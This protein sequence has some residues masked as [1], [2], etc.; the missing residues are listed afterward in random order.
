MTINTWGAD[1]PMNVAHGGTGRASL[2]LNSALLGNTTSPWA[3]PGTFTAGTTLIGTA[4]A[5]APSVIAIVGIVNRTLVTTGSGSINFGIALNAQTGGTGALQVPNGTTAQEPSPVAGM[6]RYD[7]DTDK[8]RVVDNGV[9]TD[10]VTTVPDDSAWVLVSTATP[11]AATSVVFDNSV[12]NTYENFIVF[13]YVTIDSNTASRQLA[14]QVSSDNGSTWLATS[15]VIRNY[16]QA[17]TAAATANIPVGARLS[18]AI[19]SLNNNTLPS[20][21]LC[22]LFQLTVAQSTGVRVE[23]QTVWNPGSTTISSNGFTGGGSINTS[24]AYDAIRFL[25]PDGDTITGTVLLYGL[26]NS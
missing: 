18:G 26:K 16:T 9:W 6:F 17:T 5:T 2:T 13:W 20:S 1:D 8:L 3:L 4:T 12:V 24:T 19:G 25:Q 7:D 10:L 11:S 23:S 21:G 22:W 14:V 15:Y